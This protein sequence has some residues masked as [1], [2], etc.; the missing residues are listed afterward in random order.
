MQDYDESGRAN[1]LPS[2]QGCGTSNGARPQLCAWLRRQNAKSPA[3]AGL[4]S[5]R[6]QLLLAAREAETGEAKAEK[7]ER[8]RLRK[9]VGVGVGI[10][11]ARAAGL[12]EF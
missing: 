12:V 2:H 11:G 9:W 7:G 5:E 3:E 6:N 8:G 1:W 4:S 10:S